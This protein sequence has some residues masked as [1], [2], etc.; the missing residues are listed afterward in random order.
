MISAGQPASSK[1]P[2]LGQRRVDGCELAPRAHR[3]ERSSLNGR[4]KCKSKWRGK[5]K[6]RRQSASRQDEPE[7]GGR[8]V[9]HYHEIMVAGRAANCTGG[10]GRPAG[11]PA[12]QPAGCAGLAQAALARP[13]FNCPLRCAASS[14]AREARQRR[15]TTTTTAPASAHSG[16]GGQGE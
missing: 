8:A 3:R 2:D 14:A 5:R 16:P 11:Q 6:W 9:R 15:G 4:P 7:L 12:S 1:V 10:C 13:N